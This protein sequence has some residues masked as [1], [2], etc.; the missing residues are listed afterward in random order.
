[1]PPQASQPAASS[2]FP[3]AQEP[4]VAPLFRLEEILAKYKLDS[5]CFLD[6]GCVKKSGSHAFVGYFR[7]LCHFEA[8]KI[9]TLTTN[10]VAEFS[11]LLSA[12]KKCHEQ[13][14]RR[15]L[16]VT[17]SLLVANFVRGTARI[18]QAHL[19]S[20]LL[21]IS[22]L[23]R[24]FE[25]IYVSHVRSHQNVSLENEVADCLCTWAIR[26]NAS[27]SFTA[28]YS[29]QRTPQYALPK[30]LTEMTAAI[31]RDNNPEVA[32]SAAP[33]DS[34]VAAGRAEFPHALPG[35]HTRCLHCLGNHLVD[36][37]PLHRF[38][39]N[40][41]AQENFCLVCCSPLHLSADCPLFD[42]AS[43]RPHL[44]A[45][46]PGPVPLSGQ[47]DHAQAQELFNTDVPAIS[48]PKHCSRQ[49][50][51]DYFTTIF[52]GLE[53]AVLETQ[54]ATTVDA[55]RAWNANFHFERHSIKASKRRHADRRDPGSNLNQQPAD[56]SDE[57]ARRVLRAARLVPKARVSDVSKAL[58]CS[59]PVPL[60]SDI[61]EQLRVCYPVATDEEKTFFPKQALENFVVNRDALARVIMAHSI[62]SHPGF[63]GI[64]F[65]VLQHFCLWTYKCEEPDHP[66]HRWNILCR[67]ISKIMSGNATVLSEFL[68][69]V[70]GAFFDKNAEKMGAPFALRN[71]G[72]EESLLRVSATLVF[73]EVLPIA[74]QGGFL[75][76]FDLGAGSKSGAE[77][78]GRIGALLS[79][80]G[81]PVAVFDVMKAFNNLRRA[82]IQA[83]VA[84]LNYPLLT[85]F[86][87]FL[88]SKDSKVTFRC[89]VSEATFVA[90][91]TKG[92]HQ[93]NPLSVFLFCLSI[94]FILKPFRDSHPEVL[95]ITYV[96]DFQFAMCESALLLFPETLAAFITLFR[97]HGL[98][99][100]LKDG[101]KSSVYSVA[102]LPQNIQD[103]I[104]AVG[105]RCQNSGIAPCKIACGTAEFLDCHA[106]KLTDKLHNRY[107]AFQALWPALL[108][109]DRRLKRPSHRNAEHFLNLL[110]LAFL[111][112]PMYV[113]RTLNP[114]HCVT[115]RRCSTEW[116]TSLIRNVLPPFLELPPSYPE[117]LEIY[118]DLVAVSSRIMQLPLTLGGLSLRLP[119]SIGDIAYSAS[120]VD[121]M[122]M[123]RLAAR[124]LHI[125][126]GQD[127]VPQL[128]L[129]QAR[130]CA[131]LA[132]A[133][134]SF[135]DSAED[136][137]DEKFKNL[138]LQHYVTSLFNVAEI[139][140]ISN[141]L[142]AWPIY[143]HA[144]SA[145]VHKSQD[146]VSWPINPRSR[147]HFSLGMLSDAEFTRAI[148]IAILHPIM[149]PRI[150]PCGG[151]ID[152]T[153]FHLLQC[154]HIHYGIIHDRVKE[155]VAA[156]L[157]SFLTI[158]AAS[159]SVQLE[160]Q[161]DHHF[162]RRIL[163]AA[164]GDPLVESPLIADMIVSLH[165]DLQQTPI[166]CDFVSC[167][168][169]TPVT[170]TDFNAALSA[171]A[172]LKTLKYSRY[173]ISPGSFFALPFG[174]TNVLSKEVLKFCALVHSH[175]PPLSGVDRKLRATFSRAIY[176]GVSQ[177]FNLGVRRLQLASA[178]R[179][180][181][182]LIPLPMLMNPRVGV[183]LSEVVTARPRPT[184][185]SA[186]WQ[187]YAPSASPALSN[188]LHGVFA[189]RLAAA[190]FVAESACESGGRVT[191][192]ASVVV[193]SDTLL[194][195]RAD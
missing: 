72:I 137:T 80:G 139:D 54:V 60:T 27:V 194:R 104:A 118:P 21:E 52:L 157:R 154:K 5:S 120:C 58:R 83:A 131:T 123:L 190:F 16:I 149:L 184:S 44:S 24:S 78:F 6:G 111:S 103:A 124:K 56:A 39:H 45:L 132:C 155:A 158:E 181:V 18:T 42:D 91:L 171:K 119:D 129:T 153:G 175:Y 115:Y 145:R 69:D 49:Q 19:A 195:A 138:P 77:I 7:F 193:G 126:C 185:A 86:V 41:F 165:G 88:F 160:Q 79:G 108:R 97:E 113:L 8:T 148:S 134:T 114:L 13:K 26:A 20:L 140:S 30:L 191:E 106:L 169:R 75:T 63:A 84:L 180:P 25:A 102:P 189:S 29:L 55:A 14:A 94:A 57:F 125:D 135:W 34:P 172:L 53:Q 127:T 166:A 192:A 31:L 89:P 92:I 68:L 168:A 101:A 43:R 35:R 146:H 150:C 87:H 81:A 177:S 164:A 46:T 152:P 170:T 11:A 67:L 15:L 122:P 96:D 90:F 183:V 82:D 188:H 2:P 107:D 133:T 17:D 110:R 143:F 47:R 174:R 23:M 76:L 3:L 38:L 163:P 173:V 74:F 61:V 159:L 156:R 28:S 95:V 151:L 10:N 66:D 100:D 176:A 1:L 4:L 128:R 59:D 70:M 147:A 12:L 36:A 65:D 117:N 40:T 130:V 109:Y 51:L 62:S 121:C 167:F 162:A 136:P 9:V 93:G 178:W 179:V 32:A 71:L 22:K 37:C 186:V 105:M 144:F 99:F 187:P 98:L 182:P 64:T 116:A 73:E 50:F 112:M 48:F 141:G 33:L 85:A 161:M 142:R